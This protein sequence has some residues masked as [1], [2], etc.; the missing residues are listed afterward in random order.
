MQRTDLARTCKM[1]TLSFFAR[2]DASNANNAALNIQNQSQQPTVMITFQSGATGDI[3]LDGGGVIDPNT[4]VLIDGVS[5][6]FILEQTG[7]LPLNNGKVPDVLEGSQITVISVIIDGNYERFFFVTD[8]SGSMALMNQ[9]G[10]GAVAL[11]LTD[12]SPPQVFICFCENTDILT[13]T[14]YKKVE[15]LKSGDF[16]STNSGDAVP[17]LWIGHSAATLEEMRRDPT[18]RPVRIAANS[19]APGIPHADLSVSAQH[20]VVLEGVWSEHYFGE[21]R[22]MVRAKHLVGTAAEWVM[23]DNDVAYFHILLDR[24]DVLITNGLMTESFQLSLRSFDGMSV[25]MRGSLSDAVPPKRL[26][27]FFIRPDAMHTLK[28]YESTVL[29]AKLLCESATD[30]VAVVA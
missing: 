12:T 18:R 2:G 19:F 10:N 11:T 24:H 30:N 20:R 29:I 17:I 26:Q 7:F 5:Y 22:V 13:P 25:Q 15:T 21:P 9:F 3:I 16:V 8:G 6:D 28:A 27:A 1:T 23:P 14:G 4:T